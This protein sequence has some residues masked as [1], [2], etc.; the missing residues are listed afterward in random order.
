MIRRKLSGKSVTEADKGH[1]HHRLLRHGFNQK[2][3]VL[4][5]YC[6]SVIFGII[7]N[8]VS[9]MHEKNGLITALIILAVVGILAWMLGFLNEREEEN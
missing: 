7:G 9:T 2:Q 1:L 4:A 6:V 3:T 5:L 8:L